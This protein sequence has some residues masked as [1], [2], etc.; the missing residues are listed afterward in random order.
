MFKRDIN[1]IRETLISKT[2]NSVSFKREVILVGNI[3]RDHGSHLSIFIL[4]ILTC[5]LLFGLTRNNF[6]F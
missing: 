3:F 6:N 2:F 5:V 1:E 4:F